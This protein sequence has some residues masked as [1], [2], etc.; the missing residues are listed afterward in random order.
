MHVHD[1]KNATKIGDRVEIME[2]RPLS[3]LKRWR[4]VS[5]IESSVGL[6]PDAISESD[7]AALV[8]T[9]KVSSPTSAA[10]KA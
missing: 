3:R 8:P 7:V 10:K 6:T 2:T 5:I 9:K 4:V 1:E